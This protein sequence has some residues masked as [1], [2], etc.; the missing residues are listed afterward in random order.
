[1]AADLKQLEDLAQQPDNQE[2]NQLLL[3]LYGSASREQARV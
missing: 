1:V 2:D 3:A